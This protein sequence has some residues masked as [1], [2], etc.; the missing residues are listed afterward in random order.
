MK[1]SQVVRNFQFQLDFFW[2]GGELCAT[3][4]IG[5][6]CHL[7]L[8]NTKKHGKRLYCLEDL[9]GLSDQQV[10]KESLTKFVF[11]NNP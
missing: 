2:G 9:W 3:S 4:T 5:P 10:I 8:L 6:W 7:D 1:A 11:V